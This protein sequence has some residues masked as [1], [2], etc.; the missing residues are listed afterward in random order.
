MNCWLMKSEP[1]DVSVD[2]ALAAPNACIARV[3]S[4]A[5]PDTTRSG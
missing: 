1:A 5:Y 3:A 2:D 4:T